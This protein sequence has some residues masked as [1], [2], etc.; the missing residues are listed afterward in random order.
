[1]FDAVEQT[2]S[3]AAEARG[4]LYSLPSLVEDEVR[5]DYSEPF[6]SP[7]G[8]SDAGDGSLQW[9]ACR[10]DDVDPSRACSDADGWSSTWRACGR[11]PG[12]SPPAFSWLVDSGSGGLNIVNSIEGC[13]ARTS[14][15][16]VV[17]R[18]LAG[19]VGA[20]SSWEATVHLMFG[21]I[22]L[23]VRVPEV[24]TCP[25]NILSHAAQEAAVGIPCQLNYIRTA[26]RHVL[27]AR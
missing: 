19:I 26:A 13:D 12:Q 17:M 16:R 4:D 2:V 7:V 15:V 9:R 14:G 21:D 1:V 22:P 24:P 8:D 5:D 20:M 3:D 11:L 25:I 6:P 23:Y 27:H 10:A 18:M